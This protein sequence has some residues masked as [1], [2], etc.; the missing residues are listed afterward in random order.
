MVNNDFNEEVVFTFRNDL[1]SEKVEL[2]K[3]VL[4]SIQLNDL[5]PVEKR[6]FQIAQINLNYHPIVPDEYYCISISFEYELMYYH[7][8]YTS[9][10]IKLSKYFTE[11]GMCFY[12][13][14]FLLTKYDV[15][16]EKG[17][18]LT[19]YDSVLSILGSHSYKNFG[20][21]NQEQ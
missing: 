2:I 6:R 3:S 5:S 11:D 10:H 20:F 7:F 19:F 8:Q 16:E 15:Y 13:Y 12:D 4:S 1:S 14:N 9:E 21:I 18:F 17:E